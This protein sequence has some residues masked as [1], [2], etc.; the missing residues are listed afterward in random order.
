MGFNCGIVGLPNVGKSTLF[1][2]LTATQAAE[3]ANFPFTTIEPNVGRVAVPDQRLAAV[4][5]VVKP[6]RLVPTQLEFVDIAG[7]VKGASRG[8]GLGNKF[9]SHIREV[10]AVVHVLRCFEDGGIAHV[11]GAPD[12]E[13][14]AGW[15]ATELMLADIDSL[16]K[17][18]EGLTKKARGGDAEAARG[19]DLVKRL[20]AHLDDGRPVRAFVVADDDRHAFEGFKLLTA[21]PVL[22]VAN[23][24]EASAVAGNALSD[25]A[26]RVAEAEAAECVIISAAIEAEIAGLE[27]ADERAEFLASLGLEETGLARVIAAGMRA[28]DL[29]TFITANAKEAHAWTVKR[30]ARAPEAAGRVHS[31]FE[32]GFIAVEAIGWKELVDLGGEHAAREAGRMRQEGR[33]YE[34]KDGDVL[35]FRFNV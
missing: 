14:D 30:G 20:V 10:D 27:D 4:A 18:K 35:L 25:K 32:T 28:L 22:Y 16:E 2:A 19:L 11:A 15:V 29:I 26:K 24:D 1:N 13:R 3:A 8:E 12:P 34:V 21:K 33:D 17:R 23:V 31:D 5:A 7:L 9:L 6:G